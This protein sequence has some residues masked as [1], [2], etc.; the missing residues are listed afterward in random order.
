MYTFFNIYGEPARGIDPED[1][2]EAAIKKGRKFE[3][4]VFD[5]WEQKVIYDPRK[6]NKSC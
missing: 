6:G 3:L 5:T 4:E 2:L 1:D